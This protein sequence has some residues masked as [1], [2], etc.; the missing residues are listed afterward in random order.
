MIFHDTR[1]E[2]FGSKWKIVTNSHCAADKF[3]IAS[4]RARSDV[5]RVTDEKS[6]R[7]HIWALTQIKRISDPDGIYLVILWSKKKSRLY[8]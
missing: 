7:V 8:L 6:A 3:D 5:K 4:Q 2:R 1:R